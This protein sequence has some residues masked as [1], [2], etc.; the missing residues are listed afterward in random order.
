MPNPDD[1]KS[2][3]PRSRGALIAGTAGRL[4]GPGLRGLVMRI[5]DGQAY[6]ITGLP[7]MRLEFG[8]WQITLGFLACDTAVARLAAQL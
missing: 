6:A 3:G 4:S 1:P 2:G 7:S 8:Q 5:G